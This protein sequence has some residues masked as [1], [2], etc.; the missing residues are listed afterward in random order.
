MHS[1]DQTKVNMLRR[2]I[3]AGLVSTLPRVP[4]GQTEF[5]KAVHILL[6]N[7]TR[8]TNHSV[9]M[10]KMPNFISVLKI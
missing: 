6:K 10:S 2:L 1:L 3:Q 9:N 7:E 5:I 8:H 4:I